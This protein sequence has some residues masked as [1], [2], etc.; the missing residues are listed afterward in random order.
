MKADYS[1]MP[2][3]QL[4]STRSEHGFTL[5]ELLVVILIIGVL[6]AIALPSFLNQRNK[7]RD[8]CAK[9]Q[10]RAAFTAAHVYKVDRDNSSSGMTLALLNGIERQVPTAATGGCPGST[11]F[12]VFNIAAANANCSGTVSA[13]TMCFRVFSSTTVRYNISQVANGTV[14][15]SCYVPPGVSRGGCPASNSW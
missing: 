9:A 7:G 5:I 3:A 10:L 8:V 4:Q 11:S 15:R 12:G 14:T 2:S 1:C 6:A 13:T